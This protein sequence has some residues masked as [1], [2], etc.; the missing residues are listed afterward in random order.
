MPPAQRDE[1]RSCVFH[2]Y[3][4]GSSLDFMRIKVRALDPASHAAELDVMQVASHWPG[5]EADRLQ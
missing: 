3:E 5:G 1:P 4:N 2:Y